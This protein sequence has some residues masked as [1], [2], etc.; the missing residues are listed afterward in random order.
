MARMGPHNPSCD[1]TEQT[2]LIESVLSASEACINQDIDPGTIVQV[3]WALRAASSHLDPTDPTAVRCQNFIDYFNDV[4]LP[5][6]TT[7][8][9]IGSVLTNRIGNKIVFG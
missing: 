5:S 1:Y 6:I 7:K 9:Q 4:K 8:V 3:S 2:R